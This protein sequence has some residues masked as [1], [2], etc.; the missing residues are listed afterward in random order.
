MINP[1]Y[2][3]LFI[4]MLSLANS[5]AQALPHTIEWQNSIGGSDNEIARSIIPTSDSGYILTGWSSSNDGDI[6]GNQ[7]NQDCGVVKL[8]SN[9][10]ILWQKSLGGSHSDL[11]YS[12]KSDF[13]GGYI[14]AGLTSSNDGDVSGNHGNQDCWIVKLNGDG[15]ILWQRALGGSWE[16]LGYSIQTTSDNGYIIAGGTSSNDGDV[17][18]HQGNGDFWVI[19]LNSLGEIQWQKTMGGSEFDTARSI[20][21][22]QDGG[23]IVAGLTSS[24]DGDV[25]DNNG[26]LDC[27][28]VKLD[29]N[30]N[31]E[32]QN[33]LGGSEDDSAYSVQQ[34]F[35]GG[36]I[37]SGH[38]ASNDGDVTNNN[39]SI[40]Y[41][42]VK[43]N[44]NGVLQWQKTLGG[45][46]WENG[47]RS[48]EQTPDGGYIVAGNTSSTDGDVT[49]NNGFADYWVVKLNEIGE[50]EWQESY[51]GSDYEE[52][53]SIHITSDGGF[54]VAGET[55]SNNGDVS[56]H[57]GLSDYW[58]TKL[59]SPTLQAAEFIKPIITV[60]PN[61]VQ[62]L[63]NISST[64]I[65]LE[66]NLYTANGKLINSLDNNSKDIL[67]DMN[68]FP[69]GL[70]IAKVKCLNSTEYIKLIK[71]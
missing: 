18:G 31:I 21:S 29:I 65:I 25:S 44:S 63:F 17:S 24:N 13:D 11:G 49:N 16:D 54:I 55:R 36:Y 70:Y 39:G 28:V 46:S 23:Y 41:W 35:D 53:Y 57:N 40:D 43:L 61:P 3:L 47:A 38:T 37:L 14:V 66:V 33:A 7:G 6:S 32:W 64:T 10:E 56:G 68:F 45:S 22:T 42:V 2:I 48:I 50:I 59:S 26:K 4:S 34:T 60:Y 58:V 71:Q 51:G 5:H 30:G 27:W 12:I 67:I 62:S 1:I 20:Q 52:A 69:T 19:K 9:G 15:E 8:N